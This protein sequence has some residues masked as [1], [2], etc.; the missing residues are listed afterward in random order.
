VSD[1]LL[2]RCSGFARSE[3]LDPAGTAGTY[4]AYAAVEL[5]LPWP[6]EITEHAAVAPAATA[7]KDAGVRVQGVV[8]D[9]SGPGRPPDRRRMVTFVRPPGP[10]GSYAA[11]MWTFPGAA[12]TEVLVAL[13]AAVR[14]GGGAGSDPAAVTEALRPG[15][16]TLVAAGDEAGRHVLVCTHGNRDACCGSFG[17]RLVAALPDLGAGVRVWRTSHTGGHRFAPTAVL[18]PEGTAWAYLDAGALVAIADRTL[19]PGDAARR[20]RGCTGLGGPE[21]QA[22][23]REALRTVGWAWLDHHREGAVVARDGQASRVRLEG[24]E[25]GGE[26]TMFEATVEVA[27]VVPVPDCGKPITEAR[28]SAAELRVSEFA[29]V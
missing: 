10:F 29:A 4:D 12:A 19:A 21:V 16:A 3:E 27:R 28:K 7:L 18:L 20:Y 23:E 26:R 8:P 5:P 15:P 13:A 17:T 11:A 14:T 25:P 24:V 1:P 6:H 22:V 9:G 2:L